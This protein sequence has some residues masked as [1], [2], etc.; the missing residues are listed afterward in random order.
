MPISSRRLIQTTTA[1]LLTG[2]VALLVVVTMNFWLA[3]RAQTDFA[4]VIAARDTRVAAVEL[5]SAMQIAE[6]SQRGFMI[7]GNEIYLG[8]YQ[9]AKNQMKQRLADLKVVLR[10]YPNADVT[11]KR[12]TEILTAKFNELDQTIELKRDK[13]D[14]EVMT[15]IRT[16]SG[17]A[18]TDEANVFF[19]GIIG[20]ADER[21]TSSVIEQRSNTAWLRVLTAIAALVIIAVVSGAVIGVARYTKELRETHS[22]LN[23]LNDELEQRVASR[24]EDLAQSRD[25]AEVLLSEVNHRVANSLAIVSSLV[26]LQMKAVDDP[27]AKDALVVTQERI[28]AISLV[29]KRLYESSDVRTVA[30]SVYLS[31]LLD[32]LR[33]SLQSAHSGVVLTYAIEP[34]M[35]ETDLSINLGVILTELVTNASK[36]AYPNGAGEIRIKLHK[37]P[38]E[39]AELIV[40]D[41]GIGR[42]NGK[43]A[44]GTGVGSKI[45][46][47]MSQHLGAKFEY[48]DLAPGTAACL[49][50]STKMRHSTIRV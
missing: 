50:F 2:L 20:K 45:V 25:R 14:A 1:F 48:R 42:S 29:H 44:K 19:A 28:F 18:L 30:L 12:L 49:K 41:D 6:S 16:N 5:R 39:Y 38:Q 4:N 31:G 9:S 15:I 47:A 17:K 7:T 24:T 46:N 26:N 33:T 36:Y 32:H 23:A 37:L 11:L 10:T 27:A 43:P 40:E 3:N 35:L 13:R 34:V 22:K 21:L 8:P